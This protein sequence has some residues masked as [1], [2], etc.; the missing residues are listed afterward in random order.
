MVNSSGAP[1]YAADGAFLGYR[2][3]SRDVTLQFEAKQRLRDLEWRYRRLFEMGTDS[4][5]E[6]DTQGRVTYVSSAFETSTG[7]PASELLGRR[8]NELP[9]IQVDRETGRKSVA[10]MKALL[11]YT[12]MLHSISRADGR[13]IHVGSDGMPMFDEAGQF[14]GYCGVSKDITVQVEAERALRDSERQT[15]ELLEAAADYYWEY[16]TEHRYVYISPQIEALTGYPVAKMLGKRLTDIP[17]VSVDPEMGKMARLAIKAKQPFRDFVYSR[18]CADRKI[19]W[20]KTSAAPR[21][22]QDGRFIGYRG[23]GAEITAHIEADQ[24]ARLAQR[25]LQDAAV[26]LTQPFVF[27]DAEGCATAYNQAFTDLHREPGG[28]M[29]VAQGVLFRDLAKWQLGVIFYAQGPGEERITL[30]LLLERYCD[31]NEHTYHL[32]DGRWM[33]VIYRLLP[34][35]GRIGLWTDITAV[36]RAEAEKRQLEAQLHHAQRLKALGTLA[37]GAAHEINNALVP[38]IAL[39]KI[40][41]GHLPEESRDRRNLGTVLAGAERSR[42]LVRQILDFSRKEDERRER[43]SIDVGAVLRDALQMMRATVP[44]TIDLAAD[45]ASTPLA[46]CDPNQLQQVIVNLVTNAAHAIGEEHGRISV[47]LRAEPDGAA[48]RLWVAD[49][50]C[51]MDEA[52]KAQIFEPF[53]TTKEAGKGT[54]L[55]LSVVHGI[56]TA[57]GGRIEVQSAP[58]R[59]TRFDIVLPTTVAEA[60]MA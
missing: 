4:Y 50:G 43:E 19:R 16:D 31:E 47:G 39:T 51:G 55:G 34:G 56:V 60:V 58:G 14:T 41:A 12:N 11:P 2:G 24:A 32:S 20:F 8:L 1:H 28:T 3:V 54:G 48:L 40:V 57:H 7:I 35:G 22:A 30:D 36:K 53:F 52:T 17:G 26:H 18:K 15:K 27:Y 21:F 6:T 59:G 25:R 38:V 10:A 44:S 42:D 5:W 46:P 23:V 29:P 49:T 9:A 45:V 33:M 37:G 13:L